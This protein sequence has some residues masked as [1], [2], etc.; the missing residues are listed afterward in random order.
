[1]SSSKVQ[2]RQKPAETPNVINKSAELIK[3]KDEI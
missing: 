1:M 3:I 2:A